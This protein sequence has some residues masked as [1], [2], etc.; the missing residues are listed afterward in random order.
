MGRSLLYRWRHVGR[1]RRGSKKE[2]KKSGQYTKIKN[3]D[4]T[5]IGRRWKAI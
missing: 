2:K 3:V 4:E 1:G 5:P